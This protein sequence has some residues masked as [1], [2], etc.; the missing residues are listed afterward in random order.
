[1]SALTPSTLLQSWTSNDKSSSYLSP[2]YHRPPMVQP[3]LPGPVDPANMSH[4]LKPDLPARNNNSNQRCQQLPSLQELLCPPLRTSSSTCSYNWP[5]VNDTQ[6]DGSYGPTTSAYMQ[7]LPANRQPQSGTT[8]CDLAPRS[9]HRLAMDV[10]LADRTPQFASSI[11][12][13]ARSSLPAHS[14]PPLRKRSDH[15]GPSVS[16]RLSQFA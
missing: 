11:S 13:G 10:S 2:D 12:F 8:L 9:S 7:V 1:M 15:H 4:V 16:D 14:S 5:L 3:G 6:S